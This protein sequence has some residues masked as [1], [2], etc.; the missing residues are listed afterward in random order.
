MLNFDVTLYKDF[1]VTEKQKVE[2]RAELF[3]VF[4]HANFTSVSTTFGSGSYG[5]V[6]AAA[7]PRIAELVLRYQF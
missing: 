6:T 4:N 7:D 3:N 1:K 5:Q 2:F